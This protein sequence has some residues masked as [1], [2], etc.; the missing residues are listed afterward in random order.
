MSLITNAV[1]VGEINIAQLGQ[2]AVQDKMKLFID[3]HEVQ[4]LRA[5]LGYDFATAAYAG[6][7]ATN[8]EQKW[9]DLKNGAEYTDAC[10]KK[11]KWFGFVNSEGLSPIANY[12]YYWYCR[13]N[14]SVTTVS[15]EKEDK[16]PLSV[17][18]MGA[19]KQMRAWNEM[20]DLNKVLYDFLMNKKDNT[21]TRIYAFEIENIGKCLEK[22]SLI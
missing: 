11:Q 7:T 18:V 19:Y 10:G 21:G 13:D 16:K 20:V 12:I 6:M 2:K 3:K 22:I 9:A 15:G 14:A 8:P 4:Y 17:N 1:F 5:V